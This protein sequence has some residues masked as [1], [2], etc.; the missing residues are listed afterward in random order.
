MDSRKVKFLPSR[1]FEGYRKRYDIE[2]SIKF[3]KQKLLLDKFQTPSQQHCDNWL[4]VVMMSFW[5][6][7][8]AK[9]E[10]TYIPKKWRQY[11]ETKR[12]ATDGKETA[13]LTPSQTKQAAQAFFLTFENSPFLPKTSNKG[14]GRAKDTII[15]KRIR[16]PVVK[17]SKKTVPNA[18]DK[19]KIKVKTE[20]IE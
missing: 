2:P 15:T 1:H 7:F 3:A 11:K 4:V 13:S 10:V 20:K 12:Q 18:Q 5:L 9:D 6:L 19:T 16:F 8:T 17:K 14:K